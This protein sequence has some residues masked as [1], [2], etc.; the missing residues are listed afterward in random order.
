MTCMGHYEFNHLIYKKSIEKNYN[1][2]AND[3]LE[4]GLMYLY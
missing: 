4:N 1:I 3:V 2:S